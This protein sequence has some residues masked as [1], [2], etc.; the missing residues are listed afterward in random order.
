MGFRLQQ[1]SITL[2]D[3][4]RGRKGRLWSFVSFPDFLLNSFGCCCQT[5]LLNLQTGQ[6]FIVESSST[7]YRHWNGS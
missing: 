6:R 5:D 4:E 3:L 1:K 2:N 7:A